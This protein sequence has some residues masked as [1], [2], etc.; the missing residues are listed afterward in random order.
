MLKPGDFA[1]VGLIQALIFCPIFCSCSQRALLSRGELV[2]CG[3][4]KVLRA[5]AVTGL[6]PRN[7]PHFSALFVMM[8]HLHLTWEGTS[9]AGGTMGSVH[10]TG[11]APGAGVQGAQDGEEKGRDRIIIESGVLDTDKRQKRM[12]VR[13][14]IK[15]QD[16]E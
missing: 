10:S 8:N 12:F 7:C 4:H 2:Q 13:R 16:A 3:H 15:P 11:S 5:E 1:N 14:V 6:N 9:T